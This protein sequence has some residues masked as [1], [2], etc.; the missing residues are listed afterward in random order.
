[1]NVAVLCA[2]KILQ[3]V[4]YKPF[5]WEFSHNW[6]H[7]LSCTDADRMYQAFILDVKAVYKKH[8]AEIVIMKSKKSRKPWINTYLHTEI[9]LKN[10]MNGNL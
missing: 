1:M 2:C 4:R 6:S 3:I 9:N 10:R 8:F 5:E 7:V